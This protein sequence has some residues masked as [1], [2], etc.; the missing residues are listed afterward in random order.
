[1][2]GVAARDER[3]TSGFTL[4]EVIVAMVVGAIAV[5]GSAALVG[6]LADAASAVRGFAAA[7]AAVST[8]ERLLDEM[9]AVK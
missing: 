5:T 1:M 8:G 6:T 4:I 7:A 3:G 9:A 2:T